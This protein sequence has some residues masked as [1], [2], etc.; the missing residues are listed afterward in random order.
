MQMLVRRPVLSSTL[1]IWLAGATTGVCAQPP[2]QPASGA[3]IYTCTDDK[4]RK[5]T[6]DRPIADCIAKEQRVLNR[7][8]SL[9]D[10]YPPILTVDERAEKEARERRTAEA[11][12]TQADAVRRDRNLLARYP[13]EA[14]HHKAREAALDTARVAIKARDY[15]LNQLAAE[16]EPLMAEAEF[17]KGR[18][19]PSRLRNQ[20]DANDAATAAQRDAAQSL[21]T[22]LE[23]VNSLYDAELARLK[24]LWAGAAPG[25]LGSLPNDPVPIPVA[26]SASSAKAAA[27]R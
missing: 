9:K 10:V 11:R 6:A 3:G 18:Q 19:L 4:G 27:L 24:R 5:I 25:S 1:L 20:I 2:A 26:S 16:R 21:E 15:R 12:A 17:Y 8:G 23:R 22:E 14:P 13:T 7:D